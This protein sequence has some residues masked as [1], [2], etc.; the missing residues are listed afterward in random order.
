MVINLDNKK[1]KSL[2]N[3][4]NGQVSLSTVFHYHQENEMIWAEYGGGEILKGFLIGKIYGESLEFTYQHLSTD[5]EIMTGKCKSHCVLSIDNKI[6][7]F[8]EW[9]WTCKDF[10]KGKSTLI[11]V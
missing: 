7:L 9:E 2:F 3:S 10:S 8:E 5:L 11:E 6:Q 1:F 4:D